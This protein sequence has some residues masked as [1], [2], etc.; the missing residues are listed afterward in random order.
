MIVRTVIIW[1]DFKKVLTIEGHEQAVWAVKFVGEDRILTGELETDWEFGWADSVGSAFL[2]SADKKI[3]LHTFD[4]K[5]GT[6]TPLQEYT[7][8]TEPVRGLSLRTDGQG[9]WSCANDGY[10]PAFTKLQSPSRRE[11]E[12]DACVFL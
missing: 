1:K 10:V 7:G 2:G 3:I 6:S 11:A 5:T 9:F 8:H 12:I 4:V